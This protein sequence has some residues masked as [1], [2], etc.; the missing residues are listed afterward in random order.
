VGDVTGGGLFVQTVKGSQ[1]SF[2]EDELPAIAR[3]VSASG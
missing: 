1:D 3:S 2:D